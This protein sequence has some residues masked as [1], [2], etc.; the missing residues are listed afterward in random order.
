MENQDK[1]EVTEYS[2]PQVEMVLTVDEL[3]RQVQYAGR[4]TIVIPG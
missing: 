2:A 1:V 3:D 4:V